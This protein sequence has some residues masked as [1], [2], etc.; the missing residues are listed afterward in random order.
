MVIAIQM[1]G[2]HGK[3][4]QIISKMAEQRKPSLQAIKG[5]L[6]LPT[7]NNYL[8]ITYYYYYY[9]SKNI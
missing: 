9:Y 1:Q 5:T 4:Y 6:L 7:Y 8:V 3:I 2:K